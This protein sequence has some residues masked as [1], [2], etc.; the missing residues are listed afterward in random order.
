MA[1]AVDGTFVLAS[2][3][4]RMDM[5]C[6]AFGLGALAVYLTLRSRNFESAVLWSWT[7][8]ALSGLSHPNGILYAIDLLLITLWLDRPRLSWR[9]AMSA[10]L[11][12]TLAGVAWGLYIL[13]DP[14]DFL[15]Q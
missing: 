4:G 9:T 14:A 10:L 7:L 2:A 5:E 6:A 13:R 8:I 15:Q 12:L 1:L 3:S 11:P